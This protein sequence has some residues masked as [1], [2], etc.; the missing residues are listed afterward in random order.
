[1]KAMS[2]VSIWMVIIL[3]AGVMA[4]ACGSGDDGG[5][6]DG[7][8]PADGDGFTDGDEPADGDDTDGDAIVT[9]GDNNSDGDVIVDGDS[10][11]D[12][13]GNDTPTE[14]VIPEFRS[15]RVSISG[16]FSVEVD[17]GVGDGWHVL[18]VP[19]EAVFAIFTTDNATLAE[20]LKVDVI[21]NDSGEILEGQS[22][23]F[24]NGLWRS[25]VTIEAGQHLTVRTEDEAGNVAV[26]AHVLVLPTQF[27]AIPKAWQKR[28]FEYDSG[29]D[30]QVYTDSWDA[31]WS[32]DGT[33]TESQEDTGMTHA[34]TYESVE[35]KLKVSET[36]RSYE[37]RDD[38]DSDPDTIESELIGDYYVDNTYF[39]RAPYAPVS[40]DGRGTDDRSDGDIDGDMDGSGDDIL[41]GTW[42]RSWD[43]N[44]PG[45][46]GVPVLAETV[47]E[48]LVFAAGRYTLTVL[49]DRAGVR[50]EDTTDVYEGDYE[51]YLNPSYIE[52]YGNF[53]MRTIDT[54]NDVPV[55]GEVEHT[56]EL[57]VLKAGYL[58]IS[59]YIYTG[60]E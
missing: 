16:E 14:T 20:A 39:S 35:G 25:T 10:D 53:L 32:D 38:S 15:V 33:W 1:M 7:D 57:H 31:G 42:S 37:S 4:A 13:D 52:N 55:A 8:A 34:G 12:D 29:S 49:K 50:I 11:G 46:D 59:P 23:E 2:R 51:I 40:D 27:E 48:T 47:T 18:P 26:L 22:K 36:T 17:L 43:R 58:L 3:F 19:A 54:V 9:D 21:H 44:Q 41:T 28:F 56:S 45:L 5:Q 60:L 30:L 6:T 24:R